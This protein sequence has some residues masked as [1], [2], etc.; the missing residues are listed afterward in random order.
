MIDFND[1]NF[2]QQVVE[3]D[4]P[5]L[6]D[7]WAPWC[8]DPEARVNLISGFSLSANELSKGIELLGWNKGVAQGK[9]SDA[10]VAIDG[11]HCFL[12]KTATNRQIK[13]T[14]DHLFYTPSG[15]KKAKKIKVGNRI[16]VFPLDENPV[17]NAKKK[18]LVSE[19]DI[20]KMAS[21]KMRTFLYI[22]ELS[23]RNL[24]PLSQDNPKILLLA[25]LMGALFTDGNLYQGK[26]NFREV[27]FCLGSKSDIEALVRDLKE[28]GFSKIQKSFRETPGQI[29]ER[30]FVNRS[31]MVKVLS[32]SLWLLLR[33]LGV[34][35]G[36]KTNQNYCLPAWLMKAPLAVKK[37]FLAAFLGGDG[38]KLTIR[39]Q[40]RKK[41]RPYNKL[42]LN[43]LEFH[44]GEDFVSSGIRL[45]TQLRVLFKEFGVKVRKVFTEE[46]KYKRKDGSKSV[47]IHL[48]FAGDFA[49]GLAIS[50]K[51][52]YRYCLYKQLSAMY[53]GEFLRLI[54]EKKREWKRLYQKA[55]AEAKKGLGY[56][57]ISHKLEIPP[58]LAFNWIKGRTR[59]TSPK[60]FLKF[61]NWLEE[62]TQDLKDGFVW[63]EVTQMTP[64]F[65][66]SV[67]RIMVK[68]THNFIANGFLV[69]NCGPCQAAGPIIDELAKEYQG[70]IKMGKL[71]VDESPQSAG[72]YMVMSIPTVLIF[73]DGKEIKRQVGFPGKEGYIKILEEILNNG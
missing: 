65:L 15:W 73:K 64:V 16:A 46:E 36:N 38:P 33:I 68:G 8:I 5:V 69:H 22:K 23:K 58:L 72:K 56:R 2:N 34:P 66:P 28:L 50:Q 3:A 14:D 63:G 30:K 41:K 39:L 24:L 60:H 9:V 26:N 52:G 62:V 40:N 6:V 49:N 27:S 71:N 51:I 17:F 1:Q 18:L 45:A 47:I 7:F 21:S 12:I 11:G 53:A 20:K 13:V 67:A 29:G 55:L 70:K 59:A 10:R 19:D 32:T 35:G 31:Y 61:P 57:R 44:K 25:R 48:R 4:L 42:V 43:D 54:Q 37:E